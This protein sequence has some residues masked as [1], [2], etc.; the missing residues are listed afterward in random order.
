MTDDRRGIFRRMEWE[1][2]PTTLHRV[3]VTAKL[4][5]RMV[6]CISGDLAKIY[7]ERIRARRTQA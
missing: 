7:G 1:Q 6:D 4:S 3:F 5:A 2:L